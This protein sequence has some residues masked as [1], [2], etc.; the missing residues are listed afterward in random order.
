MAPKNIIMNT[1]NIHDADADDEKYI[2]IL[3][4]EWESLFCFTTFS[5]ASFQILRLDG[6]VVGKGL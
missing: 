1:N 5:L 4:N 2:Y 3:M 6:V